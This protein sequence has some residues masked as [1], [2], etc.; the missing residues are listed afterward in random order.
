MSTAYA[1][2]GIGAVLSKRRRKLF[3]IGMPGAPDIDRF[4][5]RLIELANG[6]R[7][8]EWYCRGNGMSRA[9]ERYGPE[10]PQFKAARDRA[11]DGLLIT[12]PTPFP[13]LSRVMT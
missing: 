8:V 5:D 2:T 6:P 4:V 11:F 12:K 1:A 13:F 7:F 10:S 9:A 3:T